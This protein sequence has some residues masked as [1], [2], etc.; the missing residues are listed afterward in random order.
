M[1]VDRRCLAVLAGLFAVAVIL[2]V[3]MVR[4]IESGSIGPDAAAPVIHFERITAGRHLE[5]YL[6]QTPKPLLTV[7]YGGLYSLTHDWRAISWSAII[8]YALSVVLA[9]ALAWRLAGAT[10]GAFIAIG[11]LGSSALLVDLAYAYAVCWALLA[12]LVAGLAV[13]AR[14]PHYGWAGLA[15]MLGSLARI[16]TLLVVGTATVAIAV[17]E[18]RAWRHQGPPPPRAAYLVLVGFLS[19]AV[20][21]AHDWLLTGDPLFWANIA[22]EASENVGG[23]RGPVRVALWLAQHVATM[24]PLLPFAAFGVVVLIRRRDWQLALGLLAL[25][26]GIAAFLL[27]LAVRGTFVSARYAAPIDLALLFL[28]GLG[29]TVVDVP[30]V[31]RRISRYLRS[32]SARR[33]LPVA[34]GALAGLAFAP[35]GPLD[36]EVRRVAAEQVRLHAN[37]RQ[38]MEAIR[39]SLVA[40]PSW[41]TFDSSG[42]SQARALLIVPSQ[43]RAQAVVDLDLPL[44]AVTKAKANQIDAAK[45]RPEIGQII[46]RDRVAVGDSPMYAMFEVDQPVAFDRFSVVPI[47]VDPI[48]GM[49][50]VRIAEAGAA[51][52]G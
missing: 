23:V 46:Y 7:V 14:P 35:I 3:I 28:A 39:G 25:G 24:A 33:L 34:V 17:A 48:N 19:I 15:L 52:P 8:A 29:T 10:A 5:G 16:E 47:L 31:R 30:L 11:F 32:Q 40:P 50:V 51:A 21:L 37:A 27:L 45:G 42:G 2:A 20:L 43:L 22:Q 38:A 26:P 36:P 18:F 6:G 13:T 12:W 41:R 49:W 44:T 9:T 4:P 1:T